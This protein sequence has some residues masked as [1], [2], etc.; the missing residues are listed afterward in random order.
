GNQGQKATYADSLG[1]TVAEAEALNVKSRTLIATPIEVVG[2]RWGVLV[3]DCRKDVKITAAESSI[4]RRIL[5]Y[6]V[7]AISGILTEA[8]LRPRKCPWPLAW[9]RPSSRP[10]APTASVIG[11][12]H[13]TCPR[14]P[15]WILPDPGWSAPSVSITLKK[16]SGRAVAPCGWTRRPT[17]KLTSS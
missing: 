6:S 13:L 17:R 10:R 2:E 5:N 16:Q 15:R 4:Q 7:A 1:M 11:S 8:A 14:R 3:L 9:F 12:R